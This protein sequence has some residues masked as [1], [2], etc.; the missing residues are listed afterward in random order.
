MSS[1]GS[2]NHWL[3]KV[4]IVALLTAAIAFGGF[5]AHQVWAHEGRLTRAEMVIESLDRKMD[6]VL[7]HFGVPN[8]YKRQE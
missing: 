1:S 4:L 3:S 5:L 2:N 8:P 6:L 7:E